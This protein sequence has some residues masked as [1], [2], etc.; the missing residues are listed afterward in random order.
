MK[1]YFNTISDKWQA[2]VNDTQL[3]GQL[4]MAEVLVRLDTPRIAVP[5]LPIHDSK[6]ELV[7]IF[8][9]TTGDNHISV[10]W[11]VVDPMTEAI[12]T[13]PQK[14]YTLDQITKVFFELA[15]LEKENKI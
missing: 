10:Y 1:G 11:K 6:Q 4:M 2:T 12:T 5:N 15:R 7:E 13:R 14:D 9:K 8:G 3:F